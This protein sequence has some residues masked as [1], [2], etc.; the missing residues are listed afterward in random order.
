MAT[1]TRLTDLLEESAR[2][3]PTKIA[4]TVPGGRDISYAELNQLSDRLRDRLVQ[5]GHADLAPP[6]P[7]ERERGSH[8]LIRV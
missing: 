1:T 6:G 4:V 2:R 3:C 7:D 5:L 8:V